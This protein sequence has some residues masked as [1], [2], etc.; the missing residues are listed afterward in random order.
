MTLVV[1]A[2]GIGEVGVVMTLSAIMPVL[3]LPVV[4]FITGQLPSKGAWLGAICVVVGSSIIFLS[5]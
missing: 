2:L 3:I 5:R 1:F 4:W